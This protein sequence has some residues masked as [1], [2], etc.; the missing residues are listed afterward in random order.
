MKDGGIA[1]K[2]KSRK[3]KHFI[4]QSKLCH[5]ILGSDKRFMFY[6]YSKAMRVFPEVF[7]YGC[8]KNLT[9]KFDFI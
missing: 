2:N 5:V 3:A 1:E 6:Y 9:G 4:L 7:Q 8:P